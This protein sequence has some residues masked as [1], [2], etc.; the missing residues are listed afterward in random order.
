MSMREI[1]QTWTRGARLGGLLA[2]ALGLALWLGVAGPATGQ[3]PTPT[4]PP[5]E[6]VTLSEHPVGGANIV[7]VTNRSDSAM[8]VRGNVDVNHIPGSTASPLNYAGAVASCTDCQTYAIA[9]QIDLISKDATVIE[10]K[11]QAIALNV[12]CTRCRTVAQAI[13]F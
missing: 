7:V 12:Q 11:N 1:E 2:V 5:D 9:L 6:D 4:T 3:T 13:Q 8:R 10:P